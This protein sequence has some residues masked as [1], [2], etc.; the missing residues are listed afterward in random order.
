[1]GLRERLAAYR[2]SFEAILAVATGRDSLGFADLWFPPLDL[3]LHLRRLIENRDPGV[4]F[5]TF[6][7][8]VVIEEISGELRYYAGGW[9]PNPKHRYLEEERIWAEGSELGVFAT[10]RDAVDFAFRYLVEEQDFQTM[11]A[12]RRV[13]YGCKPDGSDSVGG[14]Q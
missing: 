12:S 7:R 3:E 10:V 13:C 2:Q 9:C 5:E 14:C 1:M 8:V 11:R 6:S 4:I